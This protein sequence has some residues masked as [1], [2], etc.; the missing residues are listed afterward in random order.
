MYSN[1]SFSKENYTVDVNK[2]LR[3]G[4]I[5]GSTKI[6]INEGN[7]SV[8]VRN[9]DQKDYSRVMEIIKW[10]EN[11]RKMDLL[12]HLSSFFLSVL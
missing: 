7:K 12:E 2:V 10:E 8:L 6:S 4:K 3:H 11:R 9:F 5:E 1:D